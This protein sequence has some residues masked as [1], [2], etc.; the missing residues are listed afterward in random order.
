MTAILGLSLD[1]VSGFAS[2]VWAPTGISLA[3]ITLFGIKYWPGVFLGAFLANF[4]S[5][6]PPQ[7]A[8]G[9]AAG[10]SLEALIGAFLLYKFGFNPTIERL[11]DA[12]YLIGLAA[13][14]STL[15]SATIGTIILLEGNIISLSDFQKTWFAWWIGDMLGNLV[16][17]PLIFVWVKKG[18]Y[19]LEF[20]R[21]IE[22]CFMFTLLILLGTFVFGEFF[23]FDTRNLPIPYLVLPPLLW[24]AIRFGQLESVTAVFILML[25]SVWGTVLGSGVF[26]RARLAESLFL[27]QGFIGLHAATFLLIGAIVSERDQF[28]K[29]KDEFLSITSHELKNPI[30]TIKAYTQILIKLLSQ[31]KK[32]SG[33]VNKM[34]FEIDRILR[35]INDL[36]DFNKIRVG[37]LVL[38]Y[39]IF[40]LDQLIKDTV[41]GVSKLSRKHKIL[42][43][44]DNIMIEADKF[45]ISQVLINLLTN[46][47]KF[48]PKSEKIIVIAKKDKD[49]ALVSIKDFGVGIAK[50]NQKEIFNRFYQTESSLKGD[51]KGLGLGL[52]ITQEIIK[53]HKGEIRVESRL[54]R[55]STFSFKLPIKRD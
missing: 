18:P 44:T 47:L 20:S 29:R 37:K 15:I 39:E 13:I 31:D 38:E 5:G 25:I 26:A 12:I 3:F 21:F 7:I 32:L 51:K 33:Y 16:I 50:V 41:K 42:V 22:L 34:D 8:L 46:A 2:L 45:R 53:H 35:L 6:A 55:G 1:A 27:L 52:F 19:K 40:S 11:K 17:A 9:I 43:N 30:T 4:Y 28:E 24:I 49:F 23:N 14:L 10:N 36:L 48:S 54:G